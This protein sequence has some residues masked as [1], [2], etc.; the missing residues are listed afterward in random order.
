MTV[1]LVKIK[2]ILGIVLCAVGVVGTLVPIVP[3]VPIVLAGL[4][5]MGSDHPLVVKLKERLKRWRSGANKN[6][7]Q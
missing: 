7:T 5:L 2:V 1:L 3:G 6:S 4:A